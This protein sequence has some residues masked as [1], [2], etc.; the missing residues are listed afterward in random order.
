M[1]VF[2]IEHLV[3][4]VVIGVSRQSP[5]SEKELDYDDGYVDTNEL[6]EIEENAFE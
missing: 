6:L 5:D 2:L 4:G 1:S 3:V